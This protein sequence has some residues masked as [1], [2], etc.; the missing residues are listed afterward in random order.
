MAG[1]KTKRDPCS[2][3]HTMLMNNYSVPLLVQAFGLSP[4]GSSLDLRR[5]GSKLL[6]CFAL[7]SLR[8]LSVCRLES[9]VRSFALLIGGLGKL[10]R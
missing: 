6:I 7:I 8:L 10:R 4:L 5:L 1:C 2:I 9:G 3:V